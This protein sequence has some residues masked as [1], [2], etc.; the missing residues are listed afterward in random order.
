VVNAE[1]FFVTFL[2][3][4]IE[5]GEILTEVRLPAQGDGWGW[6]FQEVCR[7]E[8]DFAMVGAISQV[9]LDENDTCRASRITMFGVG[10]APVRMTKAE[11][12]LSGR[13]LDAQALEEVA[14]VVAEALD[15]PS[16]IHAS[17]EY[18]KEVG[19]VMARRTLD[20][21]RRRAKGETG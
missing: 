6:G 20:E 3:T 12:L 14:R 13:P 18:R 21:A 1:D 7:R 17:A 9:Q 5:P 15:P 10:G 19:G 16:D 8:G 2:T 11:E 4:T